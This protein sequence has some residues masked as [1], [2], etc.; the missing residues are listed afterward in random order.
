MLAR[1]A[2][3]QLS[4]S[5]AVPDLN[6]W[7]PLVVPADSFMALGDNRDASYD[8]RYRGFAPLT[9]IIGTPRVIYFSRNVFEEPN[10]G[11]APGA[12]RWTRI[13]RTF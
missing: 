11:A 10:G 3:Y 5:D 4:R 9:S 1:Q 2:P 6:D 12:V 13:G 8:S 7:G